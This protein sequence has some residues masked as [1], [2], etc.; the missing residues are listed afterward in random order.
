MLFRA[1]VS[2]GVTRGHGVLFPAL[3]DPD[4]EEEHGSASRRVGDD[5]RSSSTEPGEI[6]VASLHKPAA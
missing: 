5:G 2:S 1:R 3:P 4:P 6:R